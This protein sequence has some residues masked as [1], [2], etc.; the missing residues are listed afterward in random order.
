ML[1]ISLEQPSDSAA[2][3]V[4][5][6]EHHLHAAETNLRRARTSYDALLATLANQLGP[7][8]N[9]APAGVRLSRNERRVALLVAS[10]RNNAEV[11]AALC[12]SV[13]TVRSQLRTVY[14]KLGIHSRWQLAGV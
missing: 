12:I 4:L 14:R 11:A 1:A 8:L 3:M 2:A 9:V 10:G 13:H 5:Q 7:S 6:L